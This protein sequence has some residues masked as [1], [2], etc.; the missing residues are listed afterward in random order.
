MPFRRMPRAYGWLKHHVFTSMTLAAVCLWCVRR[1]RLPLSPSVSHK[2]TMSANV[3]SH[4]MAAALTP[5]QRWAGQTTGLYS[6][7]L[8]RLESPRSRHQQIRCLVRS[9]FLFIDDVF[10]L[11]PHL[12][13]GR[14][15]SLGTLLQDANPIVGAAPF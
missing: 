2:G 10:S 12:G 5:H 6:M 8:W 3:L 4:P 13:K 1:A 11:C 7:Q 15:G 14:G 9:H